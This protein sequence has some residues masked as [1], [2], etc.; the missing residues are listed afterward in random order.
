MRLSLSVLQRLGK[1]SL[2]SP[3]GDGGALGLQAGRGRE[4]IEQTV[5]SVML[6]DPRRVRAGG[7]LQ[8][9]PRV[10]WCPAEPWPGGSES[11]TDDAPTL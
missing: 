3:R 11:S 4:W 5:H 7:Q 9:F 6:S 2:L 10:Y 8:C 1:A